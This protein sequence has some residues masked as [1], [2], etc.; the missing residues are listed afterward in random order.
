MDEIKLGSY[1][2]SANSEFPQITETTHLVQSNDFGQEGHGG[3][4]WGGINTNMYR[5]FGYAGRDCESVE[6]IGNGP[7]IQVDAW[8]LSGLRPELRFRRTCNGRCRA[9]LFR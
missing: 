2:S 5:E 1:S 3:H 7:T 6:P 4:N 8:L 9:A